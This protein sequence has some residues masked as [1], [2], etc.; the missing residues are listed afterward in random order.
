MNTK[1]SHLFFRLIPGLIIIAFLMFSWGIR[2]AAAGMSSLPLPAQSI[3]SAVLGWDNPSYH[4]NTQGNGLYA[5][6]PKHAFA[7]NFTPV[8]QAKLTASDGGA[9]TFSVATQ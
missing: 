2:P 7:M 5:E 9:E 4:A 3:I 1:R 8:Q 6:N